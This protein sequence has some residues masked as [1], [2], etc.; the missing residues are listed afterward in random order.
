MA[1]KKAPAGKKGKGLRKLPKAVRNKMGYAKKGTK[2]SK[3]MKYGGTAMKPKMKKGGKAMK[4]KK[5]M[6]KRKY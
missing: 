3:K 1:M 2:V 5:G 4:A 6:V